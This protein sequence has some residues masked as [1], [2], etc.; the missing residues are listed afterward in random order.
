M[1]LA[2]APLAADASTKPSWERTV[3]V[4]AVPSGEAK[5]FLLETVT[6]SLCPKGPCWLFGQ[7][8]TQ[9]ARAEIGL[10]LQPIKSLVSSR[11]LPRTS[12]SAHVVSSNATGA[13]VELSVDGPAA[14][15]VHVTTAARGAFTDSAF[16][17]LAGEKRGLGFEAWAEHGALDAELFASSLRVHWLNE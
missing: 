1:S 16:H 3:R 12:V 14:L 4:E 5:R 6:D 7:E 13:Q 15:Y 2:I 11:T 17:L 9:A 8:G 10:P